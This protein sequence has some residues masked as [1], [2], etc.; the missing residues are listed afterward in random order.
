M[1]AD[2]DEHVGETSLLK[3]SLLHGVNGSTNQ[4]PQCTYLPSFVW[5]FRSFGCACIVVLTPFLT[6]P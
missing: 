6:T 4:G 3:Q 2:I 5:G 1:L